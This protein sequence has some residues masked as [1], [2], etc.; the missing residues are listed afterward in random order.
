MSCL[1]SF[2]FLPF[3]CSHYLLRLEAIP[4]FPPLSLSTQAEKGYVYDVTLRPSSQKKKKVC[5]LD[6]RKFVNT[7]ECRNWREN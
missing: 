2:F 7:D 4:A 3:S 6:E 5:L 1:D